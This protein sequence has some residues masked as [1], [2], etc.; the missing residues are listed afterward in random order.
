MLRQSR[1]NHYF[2]RKLDVYAERA[3]S[4]S[5]ALPVNLCIALSKGGFF[6]LNNS[7]YYIPPKELLYE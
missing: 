6:L 3:R 4:P 1:H 2:H 5:R 7:Y